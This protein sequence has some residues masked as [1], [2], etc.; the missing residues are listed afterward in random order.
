MSGLAPSD[1]LNDGEGDTMPATDGSSALLD[2]WFHQFGWVGPL[3][4]TDKFMAAMI[5]GQPGR[6]YIYGGSTHEG[7]PHEGFPAEID[8]LREALRE[9]THVEF[10]TVED[11]HAFAQAALDG[12]DAP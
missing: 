4:D 6:Q 10:R 11:M 1:N 9:I 3:L 5:D 8:R 2:P 12:R 7:K